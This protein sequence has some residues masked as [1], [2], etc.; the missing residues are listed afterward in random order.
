VL[1]V[2]NFFIFELLFSLLRTYRFSLLVSFV[3]LCTMWSGPKSSLTRFSLFT[4]TRFADDVSYHCVYFFLEPVFHSQLGPSSSG[5]GGVSDIRPHPSLHS[6]SAFR[7]IGIQ[8]PFF[9]Q[10]PFCAWRVRLLCGEASLSPP[11][12]SKAFSVPVPHS[13]LLCAVLA[14]R[15]RLPCSFSAPLISNPFFFFEPGSE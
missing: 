6:C 5:V 12:R 15:P 3:P 14:V 10:V 7:S 13:I 4:T 8:H 2:W 11:P 9:M 1:P